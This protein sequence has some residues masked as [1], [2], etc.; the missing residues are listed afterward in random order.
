MRRLAGG[1]PSKGS[2]VMAMVAVV[3]MMRKQKAGRSC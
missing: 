3:R 2:K 1:S